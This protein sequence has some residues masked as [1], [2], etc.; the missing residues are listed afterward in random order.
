MTLRVVP[1]LENADWRRFDK[2]RDW[3][4]LTGAASTSYAAAK[5]R[6]G[7]PLVGCGRYARLTTKVDVTPEG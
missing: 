3:R 4:T 1:R 6:A 5:S 7:Q 2:L